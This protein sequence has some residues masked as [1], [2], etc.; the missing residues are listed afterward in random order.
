MT[1]IPAQDRFGFPM[2]WAIDF[3]RAMHAFDRARRHWTPRQ[4]GSLA[5][6]TKLLDGSPAE[7]LASPALSTPRSF[8][9]HLNAGMASAHIGDGRARQL[10]DTARRIDPARFERV[11]RRSPDA[12]VELILP[13]SA[14]SGGMKVQLGLARSL[15]ELGYRVSVAQ[16]RGRDVHDAPGLDAFERVVAVD[17]HEQLR[18]HLRR[19]EPGLTI[20]GCWIDYHAVL[21]SVAGP[22][23]G[24]SGGEPTL[25]E[26]EGFDDPFLRFRDLVHH[27]PVRLM[28]CS[29]FVQHRYDTCFDRRSAYVPVAIDDLFFEQAPPPPPPPFRVLLVARDDLPDKGLA[30][31]VPAIR[32]LQERAFPIEIVW[33]TPR[34]PAVF[35]DLPCELHVDPAPHEI[36]RLFASCHILVYPPLVDG[37]GLPPMEAMATGVPVIVTAS[38][39]SGEFAFGD[40]NCV[41]V[42]RKDVVAIEQAVERLCSHPD[43]VARLAARGRQTAARYRRAERRESLRTHIADALAPNGAIAVDFRS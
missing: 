42:E 4:A 7:A 33:V 37:L 40:W 13:F 3:R 27:L 29:R 30:F 18:A 19:V 36:P 38:G 11:M 23:V 8:A 17:G 14:E 20:V 10:L 6:A 28:T 26:T 24:F 39:G 22:V 34:P 9:E 16:V 21:A 1:I 25:N 41:V 15:V 32:R 12:G 31:A 5:A 43:L 2:S 35:V